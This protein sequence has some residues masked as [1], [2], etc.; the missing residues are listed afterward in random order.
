[1]RIMAVS[2]TVAC[3]LSIALS[4]G[5]GSYSVSAGRSLILARD[6]KAL[7]PIVV[8]RS[9][10]VVQFAAKELKHYLDRITGAEFRIVAKAE[11]PPRIFV[12]DCPEA[13]AA[14]LDVGTLKR[15]AFYRAVEGDDLYPIG[16]TDWRKIEFEVSTPKQFGKGRPYVRLNL[17]GA[18]GTAW[19]D[20]VELRETTE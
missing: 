1:M 9:D 3:A 6:G 14:G 12:G 4:L 5:P 13:R 7:A 19:F 11:R 20:E 10:G 16:T 17:Q 18:T 2:P 8:S 15:D